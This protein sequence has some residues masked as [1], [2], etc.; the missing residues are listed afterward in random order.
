MQAVAE[1]QT[2]TCPKCNRESEPGATRCGVC[3]RKLPEAPA[4]ALPGVHLTGIDLSIGAWIKVFWRAGIAL[5]L[6]AAIFGVIGA[7]I[8]A[9]F[10]RAIVGR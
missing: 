7:V 4:A 2:V 10:I 6:V 3:W 1:A 8:D 5:A 9:L